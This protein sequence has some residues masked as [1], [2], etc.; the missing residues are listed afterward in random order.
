MTDVGLWPQDY[1]ASRKRFVELASNHGAELET[2]PIDA[3][4]PGGEQLTIDVAA[5][6]SKQ[7]KH[8]IVVTSGVHGV[9][10]FIGA[11]IQCQ[12]LQTLASAGAASQ[13][14]ILMIH[15]MNPWGFANLRRVNENN[16]DLNRNF[17]GSVTQ[18]GSPN[19]EYAALDQVINPRHAPTVTGEIKYWLQASSLIARNRG[20]RP[21][22]KAI[23]E[24]QYEFPKGLFYGGSALSQSCNIAQA[25][26]LRYSSFVEQVSL[27]DIHSGLGPAASPTLI[28]NTNLLPH[29]SQQEWLH[30]LYGLPVILD[31]S[32]E[33]TYN[34]HGT[35]S[36]WCEQALAN[37]RYLY[38]C[39]EI[40]T[41]NPIALF[42]ALRR[43]NQAHHWMES[44]N[45]EEARKF[46]HELL[47]VFAPGSRRWKIRATTRGMRVFNTT[48]ALYATR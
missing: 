17:I 18:Q 28:A 4:G 31:N 42:S 22:F 20:I 32:A 39:V 25:L 16:I 34:A 15:A 9:E 3:V 1:F 40:G 29:V 35:F 12:I 37:K 36:Q 5:W 24:G 27:L 47:S 2:H 46:K 33:N 23:A 13:T 11:H 6:T 10:G 19:H 43:E 30:N 7:D 21:L 38:L 8:L 26:I 44:N 48:L 45:P 41:V 14:G